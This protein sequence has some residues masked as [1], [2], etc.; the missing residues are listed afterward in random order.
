[1]LSI[2]V[3]LTP[4]L[5]T[6]GALSKSTVVVVDILRA[7]S[8]WITALYHGVES[9]TP[10]ASLEDC[11][12][13]KQDGYLVAAERVGEKVP[14]FDLGNSPFEYMENRVHKKKIAVTTTNGTR[15]ILKSKGAKE[16]LVGSFL[17]MGAIID[18][19]KSAD[20]ILIVCAGWEGQPGMEDVV[21]AG[22][23]INALS[24]RNP[25]L[26]D[27]AK[28]AHKLF[29]RSPGDPLALA[30]KSSHVKRLIKLGL[31]KDIAFCFKKN[32]YPILGMVKNGIICKA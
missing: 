12:A 4:D 14:G 10:Y 17:N 13:R 25:F 9:I 2:D 3:S 1:M 19:L 18:R 21:Y 15:A 24:R 20:Q 26:T 30:R 7:T 32:K 5:V 22:A 11:L 29:L 23:L 27:S 31:N 16:I 28:I 6:E 8:T